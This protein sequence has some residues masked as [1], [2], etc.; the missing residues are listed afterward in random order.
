MQVLLRNE[1]YLGVK[2]FKDKKSGITI[3]NNIP[4]IIP[5]KLW[6][7]VQ[8]RRKLY[9]QR[10]GQINRTKHFY[11]FRDFLICKCGTPMGARQKKKY[12]VQQYYCPIPERRFNN[13]YKK[14]VICDMKKCMNIPSADDQLWNKIIDILSDTMAMSTA[15]KEKTLIGKNIDSPE[16]QR[17]IADKEASINDLTKKKI[18]IEKALVTVEADNVM[19]RYTS[20]EVY[21]GLKRQLNKEHREVSREIEDLRNSLKQFGNDAK[22]Y[23]WLNKL[24]HYM[25]HNRDITD[26]LKKELLNVVLENIIVDYDHDQKLHRLTIKFKIPVVI[27]KDGGQGSSPAVIDLLPVK[28]GGKRK[29][30]QNA[31]VGNYSTVTLLA[32][33]LGWSM[34]QPRITAMW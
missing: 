31:P 9:L 16:V 24:G 4:Q 2:V 26:E 12:G 13:T 34:L 22:W 10:K 14:S 21:E 25:A 1:T 30:G 27:G 3:K 33:F 32:R 20:K 17:I 11:L 28:R 8:E 5:N 15:L 23:D 19:N 18:D 6:D 29:S 7:E